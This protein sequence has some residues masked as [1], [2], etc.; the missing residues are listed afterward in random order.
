VVT[1]SRRFEGRNFTLTFAWWTLLQVLY[2][3][4]VPPRA[5]GRM[6][7]HIRGPAQPSAGSGCN[8]SR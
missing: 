4:G 7:A 3:V 8:Q 2:W 1:S 5:L 6:Y